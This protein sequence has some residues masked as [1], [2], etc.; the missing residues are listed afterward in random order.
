M[1]EIVIVISD[2]YLSD[3]PAAE[4]MKLPGL[5]HIARFGEQRMLAGGWREWLARWV[6]RHDLAQAPVSAVAAAGREITSESAW[7]A[8]PVH[9]AAGLTTLHFDARGL[10]RLSPAELQELALD[11]RRT[12]HDASLVPLESGELLL[13]QATLPATITTEPARIVGGKVADALPRGEGASVLRR[14]GA[15]IEMWLHEHPLNRAR[16]LPI[17]TLWIWGGGPQT[18]LARS[19]PDALPVAFGSDSYLGGLWRLCSGEAR[20]LPRQLDATYAGSV[21]LVVETGRMSLGEIDHHFIVPA[22]EA[23]RKHAVERVSIL[24]NDRC[25]TLRSGGGRKFW[26]RARSAFE[27][28]R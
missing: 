24:A 18:R 5:D 9:L 26:R 12:F 27:M 19:A 11:F 1:H 14:L 22:L 13:L 21:V 6:G 17:S 8:T 28:L 25:L 10:L 16:E 2:L 7:M 23:L 3:T 20:P 15:E 4:P